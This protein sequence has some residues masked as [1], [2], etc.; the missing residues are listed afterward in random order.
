MTRSEHIIDK[1]YLSKLP[2]SCEANSKILPVELARQYGNDIMHKFSSYGTFNA[3]LSDGNMYAY[4]DEWYADIVHKQFY[5]IHEGL[6]LYYNLCIRDPDEANYKIGNVEILPSNQTENPI[7]IYAN[8]L[9]QYPIIINFQVVDKDGDLITVPK[10]S[11]HMTAVD[12]SGKRINFIRLYVGGKYIPGNEI[13]IPIDGEYNKP[14]NKG[15]SAS[16]VK[17]KYAQNL[18]I[19]DTRESKDSSWHE[20]KYWVSTKDIAATGEGVKICALIGSGKNQVDT[21]GSLGEYIVLNPKKPILYS[22]HENAI[23]TEHEIYSD[24][25]ESVY[26]NMINL[27]LKDSEIYDYEIEAIPYITKEQSLSDFSLI[28]RW[29][30]RNSSYLVAQTF[31]WENTFYILTNN[32]KDDITTNLNGFNYW[33]WDGQGGDDSTKTTLNIDTSFAGATFLNIKSH[34]YF[35]G[36]FQYL[37]WNFD[38]LRTYEKPFTNVNYD[39]VWASPKSVNTEVGS[40]K[41][42]DQFGNPFKVRIING[43]ENGFDIS[44]HSIN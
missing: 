22:E 34:N 39:Y 36:G 1:I 38:P 15:W 19:I 42:R 26:A 17:N 30:K 35:I 27:Q 31:Y 20:F 12:E 32:S 2:S 25:H 40:V 9:M 23:I 21:C 7:P 3:S 28:G 8:G 6:S 13:E 5:V 4:Y 37:G 16:R 11:D 29:A 44:L 33:M 41:G 10:F 24:N 18:N 14:I 43:E